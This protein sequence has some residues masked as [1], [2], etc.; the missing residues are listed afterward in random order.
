[1]KSKY[2]EQSYHLSNH[3]HPYSQKLF[4]IAS[5][6]SIIVIPIIVGTSVFSIYR[7]HVVRHAIKDSRKIGNELIEKYFPYLLYSNQ[8]KKD[9]RLPDHYIKELNNNIRKEIDQ[10]H[11]VNTIVKIK[12]YSNNRQIIYSNDH[13]IIGRIDYDNL[14][15]EK[16]LRGEFASR[17]TRKGNVLDFKDEHKFNI[18]VVVTYIP[19]KNKYDN[20]TG[21]IELYFDISG[22]K[23]EINTVIIHSSVGAFFFL[24]VL[25]GIMYLFINKANIAQ[26]KAKKA[27][28][29]ANNQRILDEEI[30]QH[31]TITA[32]GEF[33]SSIAHQVNNPIAIALTRMG[34]IMKKTNAFN[35]F[36]EYKN[37]FITI[38]NQIENVANIM[39]MLLHGVTH[40]SYT[41]KKIKI[42]DLITRITPLLELRTKNSKID[43]SA[44]V[45]PVDLSIEADPVLLEQILINISNNA[46]DAIIEK[47]NHG[48]IVFHSYIKNQN[49]VC[50]E[51]KDDGIGIEKINLDKIFN[52]FFSTKKTGRGTG[53][54]LAIA[55]RLVERHEGKI[56]V[57]S[58][59]QVGTTFKI[60]LPQNIKILKD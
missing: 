1:M 7:H 8:E 9:N 45:D 24:I 22:D 52:S 6:L 2:T 10:Y 11:M 60:I 55:Q 42:A 41:P 48:R 49:T 27:A 50:L 32:I 5:I 19:I 43:I 34:Y 23:K 56:E 51:I 12:L 21:V 33:A 39:K 31:T 26:I 20:I 14:S 4:I 13:L 29:L 38:K 46:I 35:D 57:E 28:Q 16:A 37:D 53:L 59:H 18:N 3:L 36:K 58:R 54:G 30:H 15:L 47:G 40:W 44:S 25:F 17:V